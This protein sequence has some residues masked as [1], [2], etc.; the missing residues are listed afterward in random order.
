MWNYYFTGFIF[1]NQEQSIS[2]RVLF[3]SRKLYK[4]THISSIWFS[5][6]VYVYIKEFSLAWNQKFIR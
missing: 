6:S 2:N 1:Q 5:Y 3:N 4:H